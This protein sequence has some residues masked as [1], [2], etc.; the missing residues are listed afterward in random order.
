MLVN[1]CK[2]A[3]ALQAIEALTYHQL[4]QLWPI[5]QNYAGRFRLDPYLVASILV[6]ER[7]Q[8]HLPTMVRAVRRLIHRGLDLVELIRQPVHVSDRWWGV[9][10]WVNCSRSF[11]R[12]R[13]ET[14]EAAWRRHCRR[15]DRAAIFTELELC[16]HTADHRLAVGVSCMILDEL[17]RQWEPEV[18]RIREDVAIMATLYNI[19][20]FQNKQ[21]HKSPQIGGSILDMVSDSHYYE[22]TPFGERVKIVFNSNNMRQLAEA[23]K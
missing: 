15:M 19:S 16:Q 22:N 5:I 6:V 1:D 13:W 20:D 18:P 3:Q 14:A 8:Y 10:S 11:C 12:I 4:R 7:Q 2:T 23:Q 21:P 17:A 9:V